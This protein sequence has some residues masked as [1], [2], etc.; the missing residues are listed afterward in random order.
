MVYALGMKEKTHLIYGVIIGILLFACVG[1]G[2]DDQKEFKKIHLVHWNEFSKKFAKNPTPT[3]EGES[4]WII[5][6]EEGSP[7]DLRKAGWTIID[8]E[9]RGTYEYFLVGK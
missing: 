2:I 3:K 7:D 6:S 8:F 5:D 4:Y 1:S 9:F